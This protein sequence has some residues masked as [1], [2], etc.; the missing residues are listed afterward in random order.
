MP[1]KVKYTDN[2]IGYI[3]CDQLQDLL[4]SNRIN[5][6]QRSSGWV[7]PSRDTLRKQGSQIKYNGPNRRSRW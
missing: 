5:A 4:D 6:F 3:P 7:D 1:I 2:T